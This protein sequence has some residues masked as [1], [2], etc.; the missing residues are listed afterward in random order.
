MYLKQITIRKAKKYFVIIQYNANKT[1]ALLEI[2]IVHKLEKR[3][4][5]NIIEKDLL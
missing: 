5:L 3:K 1:N 4:E 2:F